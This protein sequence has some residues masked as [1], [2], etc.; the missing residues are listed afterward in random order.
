MPRRYNEEPV[1]LIQILPSKEKNSMPNP[2]IPSVTRLLLEATAAG[3]RRLA[4]LATR[5]AKRIQ[6]AVADVM[7]STR[8]LTEK[9]NQWV[10]RVM[11]RS[12]RIRHGLARGGAKVKQSMAAA[13]VTACAQISQALHDVTEPRPQHQQPVAA[14]QHEPQDEV[15][16]L[17]AQLL[18]QQQELAQVTSQMME[19]KALTMSQEQVLLYLGKE[20]DAMQMPVAQAEAVAP[21]KTS[22]RA[23][24]ATKVAK[25]KRVAP[26]RTNQK[27]S[28]SL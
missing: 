7:R 22:T 25:V 5:G 17:R 28:I 6:I 20:L 24:K 16:H 26:S 23:K 10:G 19:L 12:R 11:L 15:A 9:G 8:E 27:P 13:W 14:M 4:E 2:L 3:V 18:A 1:N 21:K